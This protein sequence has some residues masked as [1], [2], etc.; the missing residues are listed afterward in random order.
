MAKQIRI[1]LLLVLIPLA[2]CSARVSVKVPKERLARTVPVS[3]NPYFR[4]I[5]SF[6]YFTVDAD[7][8]LRRGV[9][10]IP[11]LPA[12]GKVKINVP[13]DFYLH[14]V[15]DIKSDKQYGS[16][17]PEKL[18]AIKLQ[19]DRAIITPVS[20]LPVRSTGGKY[21]FKGLHYEDQI[22]T[23]ELAL[24]M[25]LIYLFLSPAMGVPVSRANSDVLTG[26]LE[27]IRIHTLTGDI[28]P[29]ET[30]TFAG[31]QI[32]PVTDSHAVLKNVVYRSGEP[33]NGTISMDL[34]LDNFRLKSGDH[35]L[36]GGGAS[37]LKIQD[38]NF[39]FHEG[40]LTLKGNKNPFHLIFAGELNTGPGNLQLGPSSSFLIKE[41][42]AGYRKQSITKLE[43]SIQSKL[44][45]EQGSIDFPDGKLVLDNS[46]LEIDR[47]LLVRDGH[48]SR[49]SV[50]SMNMTA[51]PAFNPDKERELLKKINAGIM[52][53]LKPP[54][55]SF[56]ATKLYSWGHVY[57]IEDF[58]L[59]L[60]NWEKI[61]F[62]EG[63]FLIKIN[64]GPLIDFEIGFDTEEDKL[65]NAS[66]S[67]DELLI[68]LSF[69]YNGKLSRFYTEE[70]FEIT[71]ALATRNSVIVYRDKY[72][73]QS[74]KIPKILKKLL[75]FRYTVSL[76]PSEITVKS[77]ARIIKKGPEYLLKLRDPQ[78]TGSL[79]TWMNIEKSVSIKISVPFG[80]DA[81]YSVPDLGTSIGLEDIIKIKGDLLT[82]PFLSFESL[83][84]PL[85]TIF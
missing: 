80:A 39:T 15:L 72:S 77:S 64:A 75:S 5:Q 71:A 67:V 55:K 58:R 43:A 60:E 16:T 59:E 22:L 45:V 18:T 12:H 2:G 19:I 35:S 42:N 21:S 4:L 74:S 51:S 25:D 8:M 49:L 78:F 66:L 24:M 31:I 54:I 10:M 23:T 81:L 29:G 50:K 37:V 34:K 1:F 7:I 9:F 46:V 62:A 20:P 53:D 40:D 57:R 14:A 56:N 82:G 3:D 84:I 61:N 83:T 47:A 65:L 30:L 17:E 79:N 68:P 69:E 63:T 13:E 33:V 28:T 27:E 85:G 11:D 36:S 32:T 38:I 48:S 70:E 41:L 44:V 52:N 6:D 73:P 26:M 76:A